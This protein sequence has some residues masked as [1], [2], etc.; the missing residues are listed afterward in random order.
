MTLR[1]RPGRAPIPRWNGGPFRVL[2]FDPG[3]TTGWAYCEH[4]V[5]DDPSILEWHHGQIGPHEHH[6][7]LWDHIN[8][9]AFGLND[10]PALQIV[11]ESFEFRQH[12]NKEHAK[13]GVELISKEYIGII[14][15]WWQQNSHMPEPYSQTASNAKGLIPDKG[16]Q[17]NEKLK[18]LGLY[19][20]A[21]KHAND[22]YRHLLK[23]MVTKLRIREPI[24]DK[25]L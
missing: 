6:D 14:K 10:G 7:E 23:Y 1:M 25:W 4:K 9:Y 8:S 13:T 19:V 3:G 21:M 24:T 11:Y 2:A 5:G 20:P 16:P 12:I 15:L 22:A 17:A 18:Q